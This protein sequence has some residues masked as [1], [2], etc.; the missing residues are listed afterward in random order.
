MNEAIRKTLPAEDQPAAKRLDDVLRQS[1]Q[2][3]RTVSY[4][5]HPPLLDDAGLGVALRSLVDGWSQQTGATITLN[6]TETVGRLSPEVELTIFRLVE[7]A[8]AN[9]KEHSDSATTRVSVHRTAP[10]SSVLI[11]VEDI[12]KGPSMSRLHAIIRDVVPIVTAPGL[13]L[14][15]MRERVLRIGGKLKITSGVGKIIIEAKIP[16]RELQGKT[17]AF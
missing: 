11:T 15:S 13:A 2:D 3:L 1:V 6:V 5:L 8:L 10:P 17:G 9:I 4:L 16:V 12:G 7:D 14:A